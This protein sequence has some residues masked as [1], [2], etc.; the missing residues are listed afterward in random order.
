M[1]P[2]VFLNLILANSRTPFLAFFIGLIAFILIALNINT[3]IKICILGI[4]ISCILYNVPLIH[5]KIGVTLDIFEEGG[6]DTKGSS[7]EMRSIQLFASYTEFLKKPITGHGFNYINENMGWDP[8]AENRT[9]DDDFQGFESYIYSLLIEQG[10]IGIITNIIFF[11][12]MIIY[13][14]RKSLKYKGTSGLGLGILLMF[15]TFIIG[16]GTL[17]S[18]SIT[19]GLL[20]LIIGYIELENKKVI[21]VLP[22]INRLKKSL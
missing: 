7:L 22:Y 2:I 3:K 21:G 8:V 16:T 20:G 13:F 15:L 10:L 6:G 4:I 1:L 5:E 17:G 14:F 18:W 12:S 19:M 11:I 9:S